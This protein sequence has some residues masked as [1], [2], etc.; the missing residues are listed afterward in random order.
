MTKPN[1]EESMT[2]KESARQYCSQLLNYIPGDKI[3]IY[4]EYVEKGKHPAGNFH[5]HDFTEIVV[6]LSGHGVHV[7]DNLFQKIVKGDILLL[8]PGHQHAYY[9]T[10]DM[11]IVNLTY[12]ISKLPMPYFDAG[13]MPLFASFFPN[14]SQP[15][16]AHCTADP[17]IH[18]NDISLTEIA[19]S[20][21]NL[22]DDLSDNKAGNYFSSMGIF[23][24]IISQLSRTG[25][26][27]TSQS[28]WELKITN[29]LQFINSHFKEPV[30][31]AKIAKLC[32]MSERNFYRYFYKS[33]RCT[34]HE[35][36]LNRRIHE[37][38]VLLSK[39]DKNISEIAEE[40][41]FYDSNHFSKIF[42]Q[43]KGIS[44][45]KYRNDS[46]LSKSAS[47]DL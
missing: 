6:V 18:L 35:Y 3:P 43:L 46:R 2:K 28:E 20:I 11:E 19:M 31:I 14:F 34:P 25:I 7:V 27:G 41:G 4:I 42:R 12:S 29:A 10:E 38:T 44:P 17:I 39:T 40:C 5:D 33:L 45:A 24:G 8:H 47:T 15:E 36:I 37:S 9:E 16:E 23:M 30:E 21:R 22:A 32:Y 1:I 26:S 13:N